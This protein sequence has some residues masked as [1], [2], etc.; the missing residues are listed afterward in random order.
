[1]TP[2]TVT[3]EL[4]SAPIADR[5]LY[6]D[7][8]LW[9]AVAERAGRSAPAGWAELPDERDLPLARVETP[10]GWWWAASAVVPSG[11]EAV[12]HL[13]RVPLVEEAGRWTP[14][15]SLNQGAGPDKRIRRPYYS[16]PGMRV[17]SWTCVG[18]PAA[19]GSLLALVPAVGS[20][21]GHGH[22]WVRRWEVARGGP[23]LAAYATDVRLRHL[24]A[25]L[26]VRLDGAVARRQLPLR[27]PYHR[28]REA[29]PVWQVQR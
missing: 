24:P 6:L 4:L 3:A 21:R 8:L 29:V 12:G 15:R 23:E 19:V 13:N 20:L 28:R 25:E 26:Q 22:G 9:A 10:H 11:P 14:A 17:L 18:D 2:L 5:P 16:R 1:M 7:A 27:P